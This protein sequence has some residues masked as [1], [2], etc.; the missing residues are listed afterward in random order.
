MATFVNYKFWRQIP[1]TD[2]AIVCK[3]GDVKT[4]TPIAWCNCELVRNIIDAKEDERSLPLEKYS[5]DQIAGF[6]SYLYGPTISDLGLGNV[7]HP[8]ELASIPWTLHEVF[9][10]FDNPIQDHFEFFDVSSI[11][12]WRDTIDVMK[13]DG[14]IDDGF[15]QTPYGVSPDPDAKL[16]GEFLIDKFL[17]VVTGKPICNYP[18]IQ[19]YIYRDCLLGCIVYT[20]D[21]AYFT[22]S[23]IVERREKLF[24]F[25][26]TNER[27]F[28]MAVDLIAKE[29]VPRYQFGSLDGAIQYVASFVNF[30]PH[31]VKSFVD[32]MPKMV[33][34]IMRVRI[35]DY[36]NLYGIP[37]AQEAAL[38]DIVNKDARGFSYVEYIES[39]N[40]LRTVSSGFNENVPLTEELINVIRSDIPFYKKLIRNYSSM[41]N[42][43]E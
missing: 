12:P 6:F 22:A 15:R 14:F 26:S 36:V 11:I 39:I 9:L 18:P 31:Q 43:I 41:Q 2:F 4:H 27:A 5:V 17:D 1:N 38:E 8:V 37:T 33:L 13:R 3:D 34:Y 7:V 24:N 23:D 42:L 28:T 25:L 21:S 19:G 40:S 35:K 10:F 16:K 29:I 30:W 20:I 32:Q